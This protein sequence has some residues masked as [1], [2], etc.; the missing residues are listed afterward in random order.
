MPD[1]KIILSTALDNKQLEKDLQSTLK[2]INT[3]EKSLAEMGSGRNAL[4]EQANQMGAQLDAAKRKLYEMQDAAKGVYS[5]ETIADQKTLV[6][7]LQSQWDKINNQ[8]D[9]YDRKIQKA[10]A[11]LKEETAHVEELKEQ[12]KE[13]T[14]AAKM[15]DA[16]QTVGKS[17]EKV[18]Q[19]LSSMI[20]R[21]FVFSVLTSAL[22]SF[23]TWIGNVIKSNSEASASLAQLK[24]ALLTLVQP[25][26]NVIIPAFIQFVNVLTR[27]VTAIAQI[28]S[29]LF[30]TTFA[31]SKESAKQL[32]KETKAI[33]GVGG[34]AEKAGKQLAAF[35]EIN[36]LT[37]NSSGGG[38]GAD[39]GTS[40]PD[41]DA[42]NPDGKLAEKFKD[43][44]G[45]VGAIA[46]GLLAWKIASAF[47][48]DLSKIAGIALAVAG[49]FEYVYSWLDAWNNGIDWGNFL[50]MLGGL[51]AVAGGLALAFGKVAAGISLIVGGVGL[52]VVGIKDIIENGVTLENTLTVVA[53]TLAAGL[54]ISLLTGSW[55]PALIAA[56][57][58]LVTFIALQWE[59]VKSFFSGLW[60]SVKQLCSDAWEKIKEIW[61]NVSAWFRDSL[62]EPIKNL[63]VSL[64]E[65]I[66]TAWSGVAE[67]F[68][69]S[70]IEPIK[71][72]FTP[73][74]QFIGKIF[75]GSWLIVQA[76]WKVASDWFHDN[77]TQ[78]IANFFS[79]MA[80]A[81]SQFF[82]DLWDG[83]QKVWATVSDWFDKYVVQELL[84]LF[85]AMKETLG[86]YFTQMWEDIKETWSKVSTWFSEKVIQ[87]IVEAWKTGLEN[88]KNFAKGIFN[89][90]LG[91]FESI[92]NGLID[93][94]N[95]FL[96]GFN[97]AATWAGKVLGKDW[98]GIGQVQ[99]I[100]I[101]RLAQGAVIPPNR[102]FMA[103]LGDQTSGNNIE[104]PESLLRQIAQEET[105]GMISSLL[106][107]LRE[108]KSAI[109]EG[110]TLSCDN[111][112]F[113]KVVQ[114]SLSNASRASGVPL[115]R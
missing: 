55:I 105:G 107:E 29:S 40:S 70:V 35:D 45:L 67:W 59:N 16:I 52:L 102:E 72:V 50:G 41:F 92:V 56:V 96:S 3:L 60:E 103:V 26:V 65:G 24:A 57:A 34:A 113:A 20:R 63:F 94:L 76:L 68:R 87:P 64:W 61:G 84:A 91:F 23:R 108:I 81:I 30:G 49:A 17:V 19:K 10:S 109:R 58:G 21:V 101:P 69:N 27:V 85:R 71:A 78:P 82:Q 114:R 32:N 7:G 14:T 100:S 28:V 39:A 95:W 42:L 98:S 111:V 1:G 13:A 11:S 44:L 5:K 51:A 88:M 89:G 36:Q 97:S 37:D 22:R 115:M 104:A 62:I 90:I 4:A 77:V 80:A 74:I 93:G 2:K 106:E 12:L 8:I 48:N 46:A 15:Q 47:T 38:G 6:N 79:E 83:I 110:K 53:G 75:E 66:K 43:I 9:S 54:G 31:K 25:L 112:Q 18:G 73:I 99:H 33:K 86:P